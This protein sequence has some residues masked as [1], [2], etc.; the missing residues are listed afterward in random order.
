M[1]HSS[2]LEA[3]QSVCQRLGLRFTLEPSADDSLLEVFAPTVFQQA[4]WCL[5]F[6][7]NHLYFDTQGRFLGTLG[8]ENGS[9][10]PRE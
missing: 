7:Q 5:S 4:Q 6:G 2:E 9:W 3:F 1:T 10:E 8:D